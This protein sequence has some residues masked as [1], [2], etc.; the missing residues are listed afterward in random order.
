M[1]QLPSMANPIAVPISTPTPIAFINTNLCPW[2]FRDHHLKVF[3]TFNVNINQRPR[4]FFEH[5]FQ[6]SDNAEPLMDREYLSYLLRNNSN[7][8]IEYREDLLKCSIDQLWRDEL[9]RKVNNKSYSP[10]LPWPTRQNDEHLNC[11][12][13]LSFPQSLPTK[14]THV[15]QSNPSPSLDT[16]FNSPS[17]SPN[18]LKHRKKSNNSKS[19]YNY[20]NMSPLFKRLKRKTSTYQ[21]LLSTKALISS[22]LPSSLQDQTSPSSVQQIFD[23]EGEVLSYNGSMIKDLVLIDDQQQPTANHQPMQTLSYQLP[24]HE[25]TS[26]NIPTIFNNT[27]DIYNDNQSTSLAMNNLSPSTHCPT[28]SDKKSTLFPSDEDQEGDKCLHDQS[29]PNPSSLDLPDQSIDQ[30]LCFHR[31]INQKVIANKQFQA[32]YQSLSVLS[33]NQDHNRSFIIFVFD[34]GIYYN[35]QMLDEDGHIAKR[36]IILD[37][38]IE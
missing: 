20:C 30:G 17:L 34:P 32:Y 33:S 35:L 1:N 37:H 16:S 12:S 38:L 3:I 23:Q 29:T 36:A 5:L 27:R 25:P 4:Q 28:V 18:K 26:S 21:P 13:H 10:L 19:N 24:S 14:C 8:F 22:N 15:L 6:L 7:Y 2:N 11:T 31:T 9:G